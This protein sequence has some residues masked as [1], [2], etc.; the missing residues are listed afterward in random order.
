MIWVEILCL[1]GKILG[2]ISERLKVLSR[3]GRERET[4]KVFW[5][6]RRTPL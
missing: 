1:Q 6:N 3:M 2:I 5:T 4:L